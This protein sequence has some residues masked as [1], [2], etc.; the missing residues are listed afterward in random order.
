MQE[1]LEASRD[2]LAAR[3]IGYVPVQTLR[4]A[5]GDIFRKQGI[6]RRLFGP[7]RST[8]GAALGEITDE[9][10]VVVLSEE[11][12]PGEAWEGCLAPPYPALANRLRKLQDLPNN[13]QMRFFLSV[14]HPADFATSVVAEALRHHPGRVSIKNARASWLR[15]ETPWTGLVARLNAVFPE[16]PLTLWPYECYRANARKVAEAL[17]GAPLDRFP[18]IAD[19]VSTKRPT[20]AQVAEMSKEPRK[21]PW[22][23]DRLPDTADMSRDTEPFAL[24]TEQERAALSKNYERELASLQKYF[25]EALDIHVE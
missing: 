12:W 5:T 18:E 11:N 3:G 6:R 14:R 7:R 15:D 22:V 9:F 23:H 1:V 20:F 19:P 8:L 16:A 13:A 4:P 2:D 10:N 21:L 24:F 17:V 25:P